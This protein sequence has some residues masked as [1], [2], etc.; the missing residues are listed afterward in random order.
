V[1]GKLDIGRYDTHKYL[2]AVNNEEDVQINGIWP[3]CV[4]NFSRKEVHREEAKKEVCV[5]VTVNKL[6]VVEGQRIRF[7]KIILANDIAASERA[8][9]QLHN[10]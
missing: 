7:N 5:S 1:S 4:A 10:C 3:F 8:Q 6:G 9:Q 2:N